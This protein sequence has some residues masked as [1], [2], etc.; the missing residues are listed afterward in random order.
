MILAVFHHA[1]HADNTRVDRATRYRCPLHRL[2]P[3]SSLPAE[4]AGAQATLVPWHKRT[5][6]DVRSKSA[7]RGIAEVGF[8]AGRA[9]FDPLA[10][11]E[12]AAL[13]GAHPERTCPSARAVRHALWV[14]QL[15]PIG[16]VFDSEHVERRLWQY[17]RQ[18]VAGTAADGRRRDGTLASSRRSESAG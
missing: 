1:L 6:R 12:S 3:L 13:H 17:W 18:N 9:A 2:P 8:G 4:R 10:P 7:F 5:W 14:E 15:D 16:G 11:L